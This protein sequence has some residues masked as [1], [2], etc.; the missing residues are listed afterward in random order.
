MIKI[1]IFVHILR[2]IVP[3][4]RTMPVEIEENGT[5]N[6]NHTHEEEYDQQE[7]QVVQQKGPKKV[8]SNNNY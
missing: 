2:K 3:S 4:E 1:Y 7:S 6:N 8:P 5:L